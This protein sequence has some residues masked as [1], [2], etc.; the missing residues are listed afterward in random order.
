[1]LKKIIAAAMIMGTSILGVTVSAH[2]T[3]TTEY[4]Y[5]NQDAAEIRTSPS[6]GADDINY[7]DYGAKV[8]PLEAGAAAVGNIFCVYNGEINYINSDFI[9]YGNPEAA[10][11]QVET[12]S[13]TSI[14][15]VSIPK[16]TS[17][18]KHK[19]TT[20]CSCEKCCGKGG[21]KRTAA[22][23]IPTTGRTV[24]C[25]WLPFGT[26][27]VIEGHEY[28]VEDRGSSKFKGFDIFWGNNHYA[29]LHSGFGRKIEIFLV[30]G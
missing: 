4:F 21:G 14:P 28:T 3:E 30:E 18:G 23:T 25:N 24:G 1:M 10:S 13:E 22:N 16:L 27:V 17:L 6:T 7:I 8:T 15:I 20:Y 26:R 5:I 9:S 12:V 11:A 29:A 19:V 2:A